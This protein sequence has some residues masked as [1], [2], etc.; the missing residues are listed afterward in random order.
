MAAMYDRFPLLAERRRAAA[1][2]LSGG[3]RQRLALALALM[4][5]PRV[6]LLDEPTAGLAPDAAC[7]ILE[8]VRTLA[9]DG[10]ALL[11]VEQNALAA[12]RV[13]DRACVLVQGQKRHEGPASSERRPTNR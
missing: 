9:G 13:A 2:T 1:G 3:Q 4:A 6:L 10:L 11:M 8:L 7:E 12:M 5:S